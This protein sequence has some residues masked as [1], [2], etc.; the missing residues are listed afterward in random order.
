[1]TAKLHIDR[2]GRV[3]LAG[4]IVAYATEAV[5]ALGCL[6]LANDAVMRLMA[7]KRRSWRKGLLL[8]AAHLE[9]LEQLVRLPDGVIREEIL[10][11]WPGPV[12]WTLAALPRVPRWLSG[13]RNTVAV[14]VTDHP[15]ARRLCE[16]TEHALIS[17]SANLSGR[18][19]MK[20]L[21]HVR[22]QF[23]N[24]VD[25]ILPGPLGG[26]SR[27]TVIRDGQTGAILRSD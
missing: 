20:N 9:Q 14:R 2:A 15:V 23:G 5:Y 26:L 8:I 10:A 6:P 24:T 19:P 4:G 25:Y 11:S 16:R 12:T 27:P 17:T 3:I 21:L 7:I 1:L 22:R 13:G 18:A